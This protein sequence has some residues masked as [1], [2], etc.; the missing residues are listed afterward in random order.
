MPLF[1]RIVSQAALNSNELKQDKVQ[2]RIE[3]IDPSK[4]R[5]DRLYILKGEKYAEFT[6]SDYNDLVTEKARL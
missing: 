3:G 6:A 2:P 4:V 5:G 1:L